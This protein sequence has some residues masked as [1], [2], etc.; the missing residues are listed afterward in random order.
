MER[1]EPETELVTIGRAISGATVHLL[2][3]NGAPTSEGETCEICIGGAGVARGYLNQPE[4]TAQKFIPDRWSESA[5][6]RLYRSGDLGKLLQ[7]GRLEFLGRRDH[8]V[9]IRGTRIELGAIE[10]VLQQHPEA[11]GNAVVA[12]PDANGQTR[13]VAYVTPASVSVGELRQLV[14][15]QLPAHMMPAVFVALDAFPL[16]GNGKIDRGA[17]RCPADTR[18]PDHNHGPALEQFLGEEWRRS[19]TVD[20]VGSHE[21][22]FELGGD[23]LRAASMISRV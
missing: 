9:K 21:R 6:A 10:V 23:S 12:E 14:A 1:L 5:D 2:D 8:Q 3:E 22:Y 11:R 19:L 7:D 4:L 13:L 20:R 16:M 18:P 15:E 17:L